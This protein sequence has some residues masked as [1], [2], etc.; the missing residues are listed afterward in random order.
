M[1][2]SEA[3]ETLALLIKSDSKVERFSTQYEANGGTY[4]TYL[5]G[6]GT[7]PASD[8]LIALNTAEDIAQDFGGSVTSVYFGRF[9]G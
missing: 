9:D 6:F 5:L 8:A 4:S 3:R 7:H 2:L 1:N